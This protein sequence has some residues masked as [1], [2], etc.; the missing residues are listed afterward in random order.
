MIV[1]SRATPAQCHG[2]EETTAWSGT[3]VSTNLGGGLASVVA[4]R[5]LAAERLIGSE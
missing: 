3:F 4:I 2:A 5:I 1:L